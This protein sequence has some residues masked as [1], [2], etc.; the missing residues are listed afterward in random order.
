[1]LLR[2]QVVAW[3]SEFAGG[4]PKNLRDLKITEL[5]KTPEKPQEA[6][7]EIFA[8]LPARKPFAR[9]I[10]DREPQDKAARLAFA[11][12]GQEEHAHL[13]MQTAHSLRFRKAAVN[14]HDYKFPAAMFEGYQWVSPSWRPHLLAAS[15]HWL[16][17]SHAPDSSAGTAV[18]A[19]H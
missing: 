9:Q 10:T 7:A 14:A 3:V 6:V 12:T 18:S 15:V 19:S 11:F 2:L 17:G 5:T 4:Y 13:F 8:L 1:L 16:A